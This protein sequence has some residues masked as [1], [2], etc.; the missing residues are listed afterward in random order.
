MKNDI[1][2]PITSA[3][4]VVLVVGVIIMRISWLLIPIAIIA[5]YTYYKRVQAIPKNERM[6]AIVPTIIGVSLVAGL[7]L[8]FSIYR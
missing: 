2:K 4:V 8:I 7:L 3:C 1:Y 5:F 6:K